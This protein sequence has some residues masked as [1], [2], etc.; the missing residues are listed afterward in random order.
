MLLVVA[1]IRNGRF[2]VTAERHI[3][4][5]LPVATASIFLGCL[6][7][8]A[9]VDVSAPGEEGLLLKRTPFTFVARILRANFKE[10]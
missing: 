8:G 4:M 1:R 7:A 3:A 9:P 10:N 6:L 2:L 5:R